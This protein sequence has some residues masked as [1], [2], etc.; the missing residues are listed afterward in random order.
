LLVYSANTRQ[1]F[2]EHERSRAE[3]KALMPDVAKQ[4]IGHPR[5]RRLDPEEA[6][7]LATL[8]TP[9][10]LPLGRDNEVLVKRIG[11]GG[12]LDPFAAAVDPC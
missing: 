5:S 7:G 12:D 6:R 4:A 10:E 8:H 11:V 1:A 3:L 2:L 9:P